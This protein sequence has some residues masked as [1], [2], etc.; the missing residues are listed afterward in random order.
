VS[1]IPGAE[2]VG[3]LA[4]LQEFRGLFE[5]R[6]DLFR[7]RA[8]QLVD[9]SVQ[10][11]ERRSDLIGRRQTGREIEGKSAAAVNDLQA[12]PRLWP[13]ARSYESAV[14]NP[15]L[16]SS[17]PELSNNIIQKGLAFIGD[18]SSTVVKSGAP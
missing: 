16:P 7:F 8:L 18:W 4:R 17:T 10:P 3:V 9:Q 11:F 14:T 1:S 5:S 2:G 13:S 6:L 12:L 15:S